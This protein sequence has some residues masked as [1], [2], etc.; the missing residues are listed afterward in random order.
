MSGIEPHFCSLGNKYFTHSDIF[1]CLHLTTQ[2]K[3]EQNVL[4]EE[5]IT[6]LD[7]QAFI[8]PLGHYAMGVSE[9]DEIHP[10]GKRSRD[11]KVKLEKERRK[12]Q[13]LEIRKLFFH[14]MKR[15]R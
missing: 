6:C 2:K 11:V 15:K 3:K 13:R 1:L 8:I 9:G 14:K 7:T 5:K 4:N 10:Q 12:L